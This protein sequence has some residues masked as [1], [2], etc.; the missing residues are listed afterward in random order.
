[1]GTKRNLDAKIETIG[2]GLLFIWWGLRW[3]LLISL[4][5]GSGLVGTGVILLGLN[6]ARSLTNI[7]TR[8]LTTLLGL[9]TLAGG[10][11]MVVDAT[12]HLPFHLPAFEI[13]L[14]VTGLVFLWRGMPRIR[15]EDLSPEA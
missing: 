11:I 7:R 10:G 8:N 14:I 12:M 4:P 3:W 15:R 2:W 9:L 6:L 1:M 5:D 13:L